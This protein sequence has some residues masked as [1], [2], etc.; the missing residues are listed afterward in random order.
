MTSKGSRVTSRLALL[1]IPLLLTLSDC[2][3]QGPEPGHVQD[4]AL[5]AGRNAASFPAADED[6]FHDMDQAADEKHQLHPLDLNPNEVK[7]RNMWLVWTGGNDRLWDVL[8]V[9]SVGNLDLLKTI[10]SPPNL[11]G[12]RDNRWSWMGLV[13]EP[14]F[15]KATQ[16][17][18][19]RF[20]LWLDHR[21]ADCPPDPFENEQKYPGVK[22]GARG[23]TVPVGS[24]Y[25]YATGVVGLRLF[26]N[27]D[28]DEKAAKKWDAARYY[29]DPTYYNDKNLVKPYRVGMSC[30]FCHIGP[31]P[32]NPS[33]DPE[34]PKWENLSS[35]VGA[36]YFWIDRIFTFADD[37][38]NFA[39]QTFHTSRP[40]SLD[41]SLVSTDNINNP[42]TMNAIYQ[43][44]PRVVEAKRWGQ[45]QLKG[46]DENNKQFNDFT[47]DPQYAQAFAQYP[48]LKDL[49]DKS[50][51]TV[52]SPRVLKDGAD[53]VGGLGALNRVY[54][55]IGL[56]SE[57]WLLHFNA[58]IGGKKVSPIEIAVARQNSVYWLATEQQTMNMAL[59]FL[60]STG[61]HYL[62][63]APGGDK[64]LTKDK[65][66]LTRG[67]IVFAE[68]CARCHSSKAPVPAAGVDPGGCSGAH[69]LDCWKTYWEWT[70]TDDYKK[71]MRD[72]V[73]KDDFL[74]DNYLSSELRIPVT[75]L[76]TNACSP[77][78]TNAI[79]DNI[80]D[81]FSSRTYKDLPSVGKIQVNDRLTGE[82]KEY[83]LP[84]GGRGYTRPASLVS[85]WSTAPF[86]LNN[87]VGNFNPSPSVDARMSSFQDSIE[88]MLWPEKR[89][90]D[91]LV[92]S[93]IQ[94][95]SLIDRT[96][97]RS[98][99][100]ISA[101]FLPDVL[102]PLLSFGDRWFPS[103]FGDGGIQIGPIPA[104]TPVNLLAN[105]DMEQIRQDPAALALLLKLKQDLESLPANATDQEAA[106]VLSN[107]APD[108]MKYSKCPDFVVNRGHYFGTDLLGEEPGLSDQDKRAL[109]EFL[110]TL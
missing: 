85:L 72:I 51:Q 88:K 96:T 73:L 69:Y 29:T 39:W 9:L 53:S 20:G 75:L 34:N 35:N 99:L 89:D 101:G 37:H 58:L 84:A 26:P 22:I 74:K 50:S 92:G 32:I 3:K 105:I 110:K 102:H 13:N 60:K 28:F 87:T 36:Q 5:R 23:T 57:E 98:Y 16:P 64:Y 46:G 12:S 52:W 33:A 38:S 94:G 43:L 62:K 25:G 49:Y 40:G 91:S 48:L 67:K 100:K 97:E 6:Y 54:L 44:L 107:L 19:K 55:N 11:K 1:L 4:E 17:D 41:T 45:E 30:G 86:L 42:R 82:S 56:F 65:A 95:P 106:R 83:T 31:N 104:G 78:A 7:G 24:Y 68:R 63:D 14:C 10:S 103:V 76:R 27:P 77:L 79:E 90:K 59:F 66:L 18:P 61:S 2:T 15:E 47:Q 109:I 8:S 93:K 21:R 81:N 70:K 71:K 80:W 108:L